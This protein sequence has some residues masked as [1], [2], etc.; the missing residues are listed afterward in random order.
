MVPT[1][2]PPTMPVMIPAVGGM[3]DA[4]E[5]PMQR[6]RATRKTTMD[7]RK[8]RPKVSLEKG[9]AMSPRAELFFARLPATVL[10]PPRGRKVSPLKV[11]L[12]APSRAG[13]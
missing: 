7:A 4:S 10:R 1:M 2:M 13:R 11:F 3:P 6:G 9:E 5:M 12:A 8:S